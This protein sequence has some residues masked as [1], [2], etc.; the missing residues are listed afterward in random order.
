MSHPASSLQPVPQVSSPFRTLA[1]EH[2]LPGRVLVVDDVDASAMVLGRV[3]ESRGHH[4]EVLTD[5]SQVMAMV[6]VLRPDVVFLDVTMPRPNGIELCHELKRSA[7]TVM[8]AVVL[9]TAQRDGGHRLAALEAGADDFITKPIKPA[10]VH[11]RLNALLYHREHLDDPESAE[12]TLT[13]LALSI[14]GRDPLS[15]GHCQRLAAYAGALGRTLGLASHELWALRCGAFLHDVGKVAIPDAVLLKPGALSRD[16]YRVMQQHAAIGERLCSDL[17]SLAPVRPIIRSHHER[18][19]GSGYP[20]G[21]AGEAIP[22]LAAIIGLID[23]FDA[24]TTP[25][26]YKPTMTFEAA[27]DVLQ[28]ETAGGLHRPDLVQ[29][30]LEIIFADSSSFLPPR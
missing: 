22:L 2:A 24:L 21:L 8:T 20:D 29:A 28:R 23:V 26:L 7:E 5:S 1:S 10:D 30:F 17:R 16:E 11:A 9:M 4:V 3:L 15:D 18:L 6:D 14:E 19:D 13:R 25:R 27:A 12:S